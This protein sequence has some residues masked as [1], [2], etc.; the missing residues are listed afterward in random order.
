MP[1]PDTQL[2]DGRLTPGRILFSRVEELPHS[3]IVCTVSLVSPSQLCDRTAVRCEESESGSCFKR[4]VQASSAFRTYG[5]MLRASGHLPV[6]P[7]LC[8]RSV[9][10]R[11]GQN[12]LSTKFPLT[13]SPFMILASNFFQIHL[14]P[15]WYFLT[16]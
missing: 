12:R 16:H 13:P 7:D 4:S 5:F 11:K 14:H 3:L 15:L 8:F 10:F 6:F 2:I 9:L 1:Y